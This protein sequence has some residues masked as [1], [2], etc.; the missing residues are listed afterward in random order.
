MAQ[1]P[2]GERLK[3]LLNHE[4]TKN[5]DRIN[6]LYRVAKWKMENESGRRVPAPSTLPRLFSR[7][8]PFKRGVNQ[9]VQPIPQ[10]SIGLLERQAA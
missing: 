3:K 5:F 9:V 7:S 2:E 8:V 6:K 4:E 10:H 1:Q